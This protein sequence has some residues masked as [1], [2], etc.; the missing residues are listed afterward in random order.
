ML[1]SLFI[2]YKK[3]RE[4]DLTKWRVYLVPYEEKVLIPALKEQAQ[5]LKTYFNDISKICRENRQNETFGAAI[6]RLVP[7]PSNAIEV[8]PRKT[9]KQFAENYFDSTKKM[10]EDN[11]IEAFSKLIQECD[12]IKNLNDFG[13]FLTK[14]NQL[15]MS[16]SQAKNN[17]FMF[18]LP[19]FISIHDQQGQLIDVV[20]KEFRMLCMPFDSTFN[21]L[22]FMSEAVIGT[23]Q[24]WHKEQAKWKTNYLSLQI[25]K[26][27]QRN[28]I[29][30][31]ILAIAISWFFFALTEPFQRKLLEDKNI[32]LNEMINTLK[33]KNMKLELELE[34]IKALQ[35]AN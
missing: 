19:S 23:I 8:T 22:K 9:N 33:E 14:F 15:C 6:A 21:N 10:I 20:P 27:N 1:S 11:Y 7:Q 17:I 26:I 32:S 30:T 25:Q 24:T 31:I 12:E 3:F 5:S 4:R 35:K 28:Q 34:K 13:L 18:I 16:I 2:R 29:L